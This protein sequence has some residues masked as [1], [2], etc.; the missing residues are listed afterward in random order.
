MSVP[1]YDFTP[2]IRDTPASKTFDAFTQKYLQ[3]REQEEEADAFSRLYTPYRNKEVDEERLLMDIQQN[4][5]LGPTAKLNA[6]TSLLEMAKLKKEKQI[7]AKNQSIAEERN[8]IAR[9]KQQKTDIPEEIKKQEEENLIK[10]GLNPKLAKLWNQS[11]TGGKT[12][13]LKHLVDSAQWDPYSKQ[14]LNALLGSGSVTEDDILA[15]DEN[16]MNELQPQEE[17][18]ESPQQNLQPMQQNVEQPTVENAIPA[19]QENIPVT[20]IERKPSVEKKTSVEKLLS[21]DEKL[22]PKERLA[23][24]EERHKFN[25]PKII[26]LNDRIKIYKQQDTDMDQLLDISKKIPN[27]YL[28]QIKR[29]PFTGNLIFPGSATKEEAEYEKIL[30]GFVKRAKEFF[31]SRITNFDL[32][33]FLKTLPTLTLNSAGREAILEKL[34]IG[35]EMMSLEDKELQKIFDKYGSR[36]ID[37]TD[38]LRIARE[39]SESRYNELNKQLL[40]TNKRESKQFNQNVTQ[41]KKNLKPG[42][43]LFL[44]R[45]NQLMQYPKDKFEK[46][47]VK[48]GYKAL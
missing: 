38:A 46:T 22:P 13:I 6:T 19:I 39:K 20:P 9:A 33:T 30:T 8:A 44:N 23:R 4:K 47:M 3:R 21:E 42:H 35:N 48:K 41:A 29:N 26:D 24:Q 17:Q 12:Q 32:E 37:Y 11:S 45:D 14:S 31:P 10:A 43:V 27:T 36:K 2:T 40:E 7:A 16:Y 28:K 15:Q 25:S 1:I 5:E 34:K 18:L